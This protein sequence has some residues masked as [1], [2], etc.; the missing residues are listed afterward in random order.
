MHLDGLQEHGVKNLI[1]IVSAEEVV[2]SGRNNGFNT[3]PYVSES[4]AS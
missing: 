1:D 4:Y 2:S 3:R